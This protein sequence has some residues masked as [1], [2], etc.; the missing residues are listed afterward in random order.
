MDCAICRHSYTS[1]LKLESG[2]RISKA[3]G[4]DGGAVFTLSIS[5][6]DYRALGFTDAQLPK[7]QEPPANSIVQDQPPGVVDVVELKK[8]GKDI[9]AFRDGAKEVR[10]AKLGDVQDDWEKPFRSNLDFLII[11][12]D[13]L[14]DVALQLAQNGTAEVSAFITIVLNQKGHVLHRRAAL[15]ENYSGI[16]NIERFG[17]ADGVSQPLFYKVE[18]DECSRTSWSD[19]EPLNL[20]LALDPHGR[21]TIASAAS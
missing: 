7:E 19:A 8:E 17:C 1:A 2:R 13:D 3:T 11:V 20:V 4:A 9:S 12:A 16:L 6:T 21:I 15:T 18:I 5:A 14:P 10:A